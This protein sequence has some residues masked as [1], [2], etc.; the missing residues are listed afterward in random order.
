[1]ARPGVGA[2][3]SMLTTAMGRAY[4]ATLD[5]ATFESTMARARAE[6]PAEYAACIDTIKRNVAR[7]PKRGF[8]VNEGD[9]G[10]GVHGVAVASRVL[11]HHRPLLFNCAVPGSLVRAGWLEK[12]VAVQ[13]GELVRAVE[14]AAGVLAQPSY[15]PA[16]ESGS[17]SA[18]E[19]S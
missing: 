18:T 1:M 3:R 12:T 8:T 5:T 16:A 13:L 15:V 2:S 9:A 4:L 10:M 14:S 11:Y 19:T 7:Y 6:R 17:I